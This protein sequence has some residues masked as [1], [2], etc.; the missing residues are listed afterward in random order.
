MKKCLYCDGK[1]GEDATK[2]IYRGTANLGEFGEESLSVYLYDDQWLEFCF[3]DLGRRIKIK[4]C[5]M[6][7]RK[8]E[9]EDHE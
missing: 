4:Y 6:C 3:G 1:H 2:D 5:P 8:L 9:A 7:G